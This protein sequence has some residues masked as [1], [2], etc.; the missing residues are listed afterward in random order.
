MSELG[1]VGPN[2]DPA[3]FVRGLIEEGIGVTEGR[4]LFRSYGMAM[5]NARFSSLYGEIRS[6]IANREAL[7]ALDYSLVPDAARFN[8]W[9]AGEPDRYATF[10]QVHVTMPGESEIQMRPFV[11][12]TDQPHTPQEAVDA[13]MS[14]AEQLAAAG[15]T[16][17]GQTVI[18]GT[19]TSMT[20]TVAR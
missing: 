3:A 12:I 9:A 4:D 6:T 16:F 14:E 1:A 15:G 11:H 13:A 7:Q 18:G 19:V 10:V 2:L 8:A 20:R 17:Q 5:S